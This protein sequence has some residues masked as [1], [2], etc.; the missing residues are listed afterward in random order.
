MK[1]H[2][3]HFSPFLPIFAHFW[4]ILA[5]FFDL[6]CTKI[7]SWAFFGTKLTPLAILH[8]PKSCLVALKGLKSAKNWLKLMF[9]FLHFLPFS[10]IFGLIWLTT[11]KIGFNFGWGV[12]RWVAW[13]IWS[14][15]RLLDQITYVCF[16]LQFVLLNKKCIFC[17]K[18][19]K[20]QY[21]WHSEQFF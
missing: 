8:T 20:V 3:W 14:T 19:E 21:I 12:L 7:M 5:Q 15:A 17:P 13:T 10:S 4:P 16:K 6:Y 2:F 9:H 1:F 18:I 11:Q